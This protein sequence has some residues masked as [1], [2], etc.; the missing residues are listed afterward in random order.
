MAKITARQLKK[1][2]KMRSQEDLIDEIVL[3]FNKFDAVRNYYQFQLA[4]EP[5]EENIAKYKAAIRR[6]FSTGRTPGPARLSVARKIVMDFKKVAPS[7]ASLID[8]MLA[9]VEAG[10]N[11]TRAFGD[12]D[13]PFYSSMESMYGRALE[14]IV[15]AQ[16]QEDFEIRCQKI[17]TDTSHMG[18]GFH[19]NLEDMYWNILHAE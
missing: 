12:I 3:L 1:Q 6:E 18:W 7:D 19:D 14:L 11:F 10:V 17:V 5:D 13:E 9:Y 8:V 16:L 2:L 15:K 4:G